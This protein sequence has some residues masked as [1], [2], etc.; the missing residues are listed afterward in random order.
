MKSPIVFSHSMI[1]EK[2]E[3]LWGSGGAFYGRCGVLLVLIHRGKWSAE[4]GE[5]ESGEPCRSDAA[6][7]ENPF[8]EIIGLD[9][10]AWW[11]RNVTNHRR[12]N[13]C[14][15]SAGFRIWNEHSR[16]SSTLIMAPALSNSPQ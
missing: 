13:F 1:R 12:P 9:Q 10:F 8:V 2:I 16:L 7:C 11:C 3:V 14:F 5:R 6:S 15:F 4:E